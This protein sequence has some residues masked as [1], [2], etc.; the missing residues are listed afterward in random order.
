MS[1]LPGP[2]EVHRF[3]FGEVDDWAGCA[4]RNNERWFARGHELDAEIRERF[5][6]LVETAAAG[7]REHWRHDAAGALALVLCLDQFPRHVH[8]GTAAAFAHD[9]QALAI[10]TAAVDSG[11]AAGL[12]DVEQAFFLLPLEHAEDLAVQ[13]R[14][15]AL[16]RE[17]AKRCEPA[18]KPFMEETARYAAMHR[19]IIA[20]FGRF[21]HRN[22]VLGR[23]STEEER[24][25][26]DGGGERFGQ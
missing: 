22:A 23:A 8:R 10:C 3:W 6:A 20:R 4:A 7:E 18:L 15:V 11:L 24:D 26:L 1:T 17:R 25:Y 21:P 13:D 19:D 2:A 16:T 5:G 14:S 12:S 9:A